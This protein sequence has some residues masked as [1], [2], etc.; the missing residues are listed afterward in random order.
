MTCTPILAEEEE[1]GRLI[2]DDTHIMF[3]GKRAGA[4]NGGKGLTAKN[5]GQIVRSNIVARKMSE[6]NVASSSGGGR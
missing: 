4:F 1:S 6:T 3:P 2:Y 5:T